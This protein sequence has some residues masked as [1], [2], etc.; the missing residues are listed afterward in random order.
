MESFIYTVSGSPS[1][2]C[3]ISQGLEVTAFSL[4]AQKLSIRLERPGPARGNIFLA[5]P[6]PLLDAA[7]NDRPQAWEDCGRGCY[8]LAVEFEHAANLTI[9]F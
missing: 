6:G 5:L 3:H 2:A 4:D 8:A 9:R 1:A 7:L